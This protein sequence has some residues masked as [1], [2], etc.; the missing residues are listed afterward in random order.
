ML[1]CTHRVWFKYTGSYICVCFLVDVDLSIKQ[2][3]LSK[4]PVGLKYFL[5][6][7]FFFSFFPTDFSV[8]GNLLLEPLRA[9]HLHSYIVNCSGPQKP[10]L[11]SWQREDLSTVVGTVGDHLKLFHL[12]VYDCRFLLSDSASVCLCFL[13]GCLTHRARQGH[14]LHWGAFCISHINMVSNTENMFYLTGCSLNA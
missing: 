7:F 2:Q 4:S 10:L 13:S 9:S 5:L 8:S 11:S 3:M 6:V 14:R 12:S 1:N